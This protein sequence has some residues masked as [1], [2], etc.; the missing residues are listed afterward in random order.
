V[1]HEYESE[2]PERSQRDVGVI[3]LPYNLGLGRAVG[4]NGVASWLPTSTATYIA[5]MGR[6][7]TPTVGTIDILVCEISTAEIDPNE[8]SAMGSA[9]GTWQPAIAPDVSGGV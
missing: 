3:L 6:Q 7:P 9:T 1:I 8:R 2:I 4:D 5:L